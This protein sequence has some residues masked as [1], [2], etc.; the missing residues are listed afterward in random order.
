MFPSKRI[1][2]A[3]HPVEI[4]ESVLRSSL[5]EVL[6]IYD[7]PSTTMI[8]KRRRIELAFSRGAGGGFDRGLVEDLVFSTL[9]EL[10]TDGLLRPGEGVPK[11]GFM[12]QSNISFKRGVREVRISDGDDHAD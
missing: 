12:S 4:N 5:S 10:I 9:T 6:A 11:K 3:A 1:D 8:D 7:E 2:R